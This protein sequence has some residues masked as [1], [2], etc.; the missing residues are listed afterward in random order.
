M[1]R[2]LEL[3]IRFPRVVIGIWLVLFV[4]GG[5]LALRLD[6]A[7]SGGGFTNPRAEALVTQELVEERFGESPNQLVVVLDSNSPLSEEQLSDTVRVLDAEGA[8]TVTTPDSTPSLMSADGRTAAVI[9]GFGGSGTSVQNLVPGLQEQLDGAALADDVYVTGQPALDFQLNAHSKA[10]AMRA[11]LIV[12]P[13]LIVV[14]L[15]VFRSLVATFLPLLVAGS[16]LVMAMGIGYLLTRVTEVSNLYTNIISMIGLAVAVDYSLFIIKRF[17][18]ELAAGRTTP[19]AVRAT[20]ATA[21]HSVLFSGIAV[22]LALAALLIPQVMALTSIA[23]GGIVVSAVALFVTMLVLPAA[24][25]LIGPGID[26][27]RVPFLRHEAPTIDRA[28]RT[29]VIRRPALVGAIGILAL[30]ACAL[31]VSGLS[32]QSPVASATVLPAD[33]PARQGLETLDEQIGQEGLFPVDVVL[34]FPAGVQTAEALTQIQDASGWIADRPGA[35][36]VT[37]VTDLGLPTEQLTA[38][39]EQG[40]APADLEQLWN[41]R[42]GVITTRLLTTTTEGPD[43]VSAH[44]LVNDIRQDL[45]A[46]LAP[47]SRVAVTGATAQGVDFD[48]TIIDSIP[49]VATLVLLLTFA[50]LAFAWRSALLPGLA[51][52]FN[53]LVVG[54]SVGAL[55]LIQGA[56]SDVPLNSVTP[57]LLFAV[58][59]GL[60][61]DYMVI[62]MSRMR[63][64]YRA[65]TPY[66]HAVIGGARRT[67]S[68]INSAALIM[69]AVF[70]SF[71][72]AQI[73]IVREIGIGLAIAVALD[74][75]VIRMIVMPSI[76]RAIG[77]RAF[78]RQPGTTKSTP[79][80][81]P[82]TRSGQSDSELVST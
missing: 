7:L 75:I 64:M 41:E 65:G 55:T 73:S 77:P 76:L 29:T 36:A 26:R 82:P 8:S 80:L 45:P 6:A 15:F 43:S 1:S 38:L 44:H 66:E 9:A 14:L 12:F 60:S 21:G 68:M 18:E 5:I 79:P 2:L 50:L 17:R 74:A 25:T 13:L 57:I 46:E 33:D 22:I 16:S 42:D 59:F 81:V 48:A 20:M 78:G 24:L 49:L 27:F 19:A 3:P 72:T 37:S 52:L 58:M 39:L 40:N 28:E 70:L 54:A 10:D 30:G 56:I 35:D 71:M 31:P 32:L 53:L 62:I 67:R 61:M 4:I 69:I 47:A 51:L 11:E 34:T 63:E 23:L